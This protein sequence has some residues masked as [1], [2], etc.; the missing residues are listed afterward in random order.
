MT[1]LCY[2]VQSQ[3]AGEYYEFVLEEFADVMRQRGHEIQQFGDE[4]I[5]EQV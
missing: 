2:I 3:M 1:A 4:I 5:M